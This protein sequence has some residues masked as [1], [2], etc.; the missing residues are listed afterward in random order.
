MCQNGTSLF[1]K[2]WRILALETD[3]ELKRREC[4]KCCCWF[5]GNGLWEHDRRRAENSSHL[6]D[7]VMLLQWQAIC[8][9]IRMDCR[10]EKKEDSL[11]GGRE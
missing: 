4:V 11:T 5:I 3:V 2:L 6:E 9:E 1:K 10:W 8:S 7:P